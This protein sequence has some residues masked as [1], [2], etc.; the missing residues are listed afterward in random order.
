MRIENDSTVIEMDKIQY[1]D[2]MCD[3]KLVCYLL[4]YKSK[5]YNIV[6]CPVLL[7]VRDLQNSGEC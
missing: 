3:F 4:F 2:I 5:S 1:D 6:D 7:H